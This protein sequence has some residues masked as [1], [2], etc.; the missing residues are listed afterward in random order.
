VTHKVLQVTVN[1]ITYPSSSSVAS[2]T[3]AGTVIFK[4]SSG[5][6][7]NIIPLTVASQPTTGKP[8][9]ILLP[10]GVFS[11][12]VTGLVPG[13]TDVIN[14]TFPTQIAPNTQY[15]KIQGGTWVNATSHISLVNNRHSMLLTVTDGGF[16]DSDGLA[17]GNIVDP[18]AVLV[19]KNSL[20]HVVITSPVN[21]TTIVSSDITV[22]GMASSKNSTISNV[23]VSIDGSTYK[24]ANGTTSWSFTKHGLANG[25]HTILARAIDNLGNV[26]VSY[27][28]NRVLGSPIPVG[29]GPVSVAY[30]PANGD[31][32]VANR[33]NNTISVIDSNTNAV[34]ATIPIPTPTGIVY[35]SA[36]SNIYATG[37]NSPTGVI[38]I[39]GT[40][41]T[42][43]GSVT[44]GGFPNGITFDPA[45]GDLYATSTGTNTVTVINGATNS[46]IGSPISVQTSPEDIA[47]D[48]ANNYLYVTNY[49]NSTVSVIN[50]ATNTIVGSPISVGISPFNIRFD[51]ANGY[52]YVSN[53]GGSSISVINGTTNSVTSTISIPGSVPSGIAFDPANKYLYVT[54]GHSSV[55]LINGTTNTLAGSPIPVGTTPAGIA[56]DSAN[57]YLYVTNQN[58]N[59]VSVIYTPTILTVNTVLPPP[60]ADYGLQEL[61]SV[62]TAQGT[63]GKTTIQVSSVNGFAGNVNLALNSSSVPAGV[64][65]I[66]GNSTLHV[67]SGGV[68]NTSLSLAVGPAVT[69]GLYGI[70]VIGNNG[71]IVH[72]SVFSLTVNPSIPP[73]SFAVSASPVVIL[74]GSSGPST[75]NVTSIS[76]FSSPVTL[77]LVGAPVNVTGTFAQNPVTPVSNGQTSTTLSLSVGRSVAPGIYNMSVNGTSG[78]IVH[79][80]N[81]VLTVSPIVAAGVTSLSAAQPVVLN[82][83]VYTVG[84]AGTITINSN[85]GTP[86][87][88]ALIRSSSDP[89][90]MMV[91]L[92]QSSTNPTVYTSNNQVTFT[93][94]PTDGISQ[95]H[96][97]VGDTIYVTNN[98]TSETFYLRDSNGGYSSIAFGSPGN[99]PIV[100]DWNGDGITKVGTYVSSTET[101]YLRNSDGTYQTIQFG[102]PGDMPIV[103]DWY[104]TGRSNIGV[105]RPSTETFYLRDSNGGYSSIAFGSPGDMPIVGDWYGTKSTTGYK[106]SLIG[107]FRITSGI[108]TT[109]S[110]IT[111]TIPTTGVAVSYTT[112]FACQHDSSS[113]GICD[114]W[115][116]TAPANGLPAGV[117]IPVNG[118]N[119]NFA[120]DVNARYNS[121]D[122]TLGQYNDPLGD[123][124]CPQ[125][126]VKDV[127][128]EIDYM[129]GQQ[130]D[131]TA[132]T[133]VVNAFLNHGIHL[134]LLVNDNMGLHVDSIPL[135]TILN[136]DGTVQQIGY[137]GT[138]GSLG[139]KNGYKD[140]FFGTATER[141]DPH[142]TDLLTAKRQFYHYAMFIFDLAGT[143]GSSG[144]GEIGGNDMIISLGE[145]T[146]H[147]GSIA[148]Q[149][150]TFMHELGHN[151]G[152]DHGGPVN[153]MSSSALTAVSAVSDH[154]LNCKPNYPSIM[155]YLYQMP[156]LASGRP[157]DYSSLSATNTLNE[158]SLV[159]SNGIGASVSSGWQAVIGGVDA[160]NNYQ[161]PLIAPF[162]GGVAFDR[163]TALGTTGVSKNIHEFN[164]PNCD[165]NTNN[166]LTTLNGY[167][168]W[169]N[170]NL[171]F[172]S[173]STFQNGIVTINQLDLTP[174]TLRI[175]QGQLIASLNGTIES[176]PD[177]AFTP[178]YAADMKSIFSSELLSVDG[179]IRSGNLIGTGGAVYQLQHTVLPQ[180]TGTGTAATNVLITNPTNQTNVSRMVNDI[181]NALN[182]AAT[183][184][185]T[186]HS[187]PHAANETIVTLQNVPVGITL[188]AADPNN[189]P[190]KVNITN[191]SSGTL[192]PTPTGTNLDF[193]GFSD[194]TYV[195]ISGHIGTDQFTYQ[196]K[197][198]DPQ[199]AITHV[200]NIG[201][202]TV[203]TQSST[204][205]TLTPPP[206][207]TTISAGGQIPLT[208]Q[209]TGSSP[210]GTVLFSS[211]SG[212]FANN[213]CTLDSHASCS[214]IFTPTSSGQISITENYSGDKFNQP[215]TS[216]ITLTVSQATTTTTVQLNPSTVTVDS[217]DTV[218]AQVSG[219]SPTGTVTFSA[220][221]NSGSFVLSQNTCQ[222][223]AGA[224]SVQFTPS[225]AGSPSITATYTGDSNN[226]PSSSNNAL[227]VSKYS[228]VLTI[229]SLSPSSV[230][231]G[232]PSTVSVLITGIALSG[233]SISFTSDGTGAFNSTSCTI[234]NNNQCGVQYT[235]STVGTGS[236]KIT[237]SYAG[238]SN[239]QPSSSHAVLT[240]AQFITTTTISLN[241]SS[242]AAGGTTTVSVTV[243]GLLP[244]GSVSFSAPAGAGTFSVNSCSLTNSACSVQFT[245][246]FTPGQ[247]SISASYSG[248]PNNKQS[249]SSA[250]LTVGSLETQKSGIAS[251]IKGL[252]SG[253]TDMSVNKKLDRAA[254]HVEKSAANNLWNVD[255]TTLDTKKGKKVFDQEAKAVNV[256]LNLLKT[257]TSN[258][259][260]M[261]NTQDGD[262][263]DEDLASVTTSTLPTGVAN[264]IRGI[265]NSLETIDGTLAQ[266][267]IISANARLAD[268]QSHHA[269]SNKITQVQQDI[270]QANSFVQ[271]AQS[272]LANGNFHRAIFD[273]REA[274]AAATQA[275][276]IN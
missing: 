256:L 101:F 49:G 125:I 9:N 128:V 29:T 160:N 156:S 69:P 94:G 173:S 194:M 239:N 211:T 234:Q 154:A 276:G 205:N 183:P 44:I 46:V 83:D 109:A 253:I 5:G 112:N 195:P 118:L 210:T 269:S 103:G 209:I 142:A 73:G 92:T 158:N 196:V 202:I 28:S 229:D 2:A 108:T 248:N 176:L 241:P 266:Q 171:E 247:V 267:Q 6:F 249:S 25:I 167:N 22:T 56:Y 81:L 120:C 122:P 18:G 152:L 114:E 34:I 17:N 140:M 51:P 151:L 180:M 208:V 212:T 243:T 206:I 228:P 242:V 134:H 165:I 166:A 233:Q 204:S 3:N 52:L 169:N 141:A 132:L 236:H 99:M 139:Y 19:P 93:S 86:T 7:N 150:G 71:T 260:D 24:P 66:F 87:I 258:D 31:M 149:E 178:N 16:G 224:C 61:A 186:D 38:V 13:S 237:A 170:L 220:P 265:I 198:T 67:Q 157:L 240:V 147:V 57:G 105:Y 40:T 179:S 200:S 275:I 161:S 263:N 213:P 30:D 98:L 262:T 163:S 227:T 254:L 82:S 84:S 60:P 245:S 107:V 168:D 129:T 59:S 153:L 144:Y 193:S 197:S 189:L 218:S 175:I 155:N 190:L 221:A 72:K 32:Y 65:A 201:T 33:N 15:W 232:S 273:Y 23:Q 184:S 50:G 64:L 8:I 159:D 127:Y 62:S 115:K 74:Q 91:T 145:F 104:G 111:N 77:S 43:T 36:N 138:T 58:S 10:F 116:Y 199:T 26:G 20:P 217:V 192:S 27:G 76:G 55:V 251:S 185:A 135:K 235:P 97:S 119:Y 79:S 100:G 95:L 133:D 264:S 214:V 146:N 187:T 35:D 188:L 130:P 270:A 274:W 12:N 14:M 37:Y 261:K 172:R 4:T 123:K 124:I 255:A 11:F 203:I 231:V 102:S 207:T 90:G 222:L 148:E 259:D 191:P 143:G 126:G 131:P 54:D 246:S 238:D 268:L 244:S 78:S 68:N 85:A 162:S 230:A 53:A 113:D 70:Q 117:N 219:F 1:V 223:N 257:P 174:S 48:P 226:G 47:F 42:I 181:I 110:M 136:S 177:S 80:G 182:A 39:N 21:G 63:T 75:V 106:V 250:V 45:N 272:D 215:S 225:S 121:A 89:V 164:I 41:N 252:E 137:F 216:S 96:V 271:K 88:Q